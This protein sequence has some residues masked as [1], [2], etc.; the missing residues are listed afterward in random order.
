MELLHKQLDSR[1]PLSQQSLILGALFCVTFVSDAKMSIHEIFFKLYL[2]FRDE[3]IAWWLGR[4]VQ[5]T[6]TV[7]RLKVC[8]D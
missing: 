5:L 4:K 1:S 2:Y 8:G 6:A 7:K 3:R